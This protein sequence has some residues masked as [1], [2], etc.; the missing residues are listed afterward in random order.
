MSDRREERACARQMMM[1]TQ[2]RHRRLFHTRLHANQTGAEK[3][4]AYAVRIH[5]II[6]ASS[7]RHL[8]RGI[9]RIDRALA[10]L[11]TPPPFPTLH[12]HSLAG[13]TADAATPLEVTGQLN[14]HLH[15]NA[16]TS[17]RRG[18]RPLGNFAGS[19]SR[20]HAVTLDDG[21]NVAKITRL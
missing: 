8:V 17:T 10:T 14:P 19:R 9:Q 2:V 18:P 5:A 16:L 6:S 12:T 20:L 4:L 21:A 3:P 15:R 13:D 7:G 11:E 1:M